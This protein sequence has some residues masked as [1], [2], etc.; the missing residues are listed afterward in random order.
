MPAGGDDVLR[1]ITVRSDDQ[2]TSSIY[3]YDDFYRGIRGSRQVL[4]M[5]R[6]NMQ[7]PG[8]SEGE[9]LTV[10]TAASDGHPRIVTELLAT[11]YDISRGCAAGCY[12][13]CNRLIPLWHHAEHSMVPAAKFITIKIADRRY[14]SSDSTRRTAWIKSEAFLLSGRYGS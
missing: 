5:N 3:S 2:F 12:P 4:L 7:R 11:E 6:D 13:E 8:F 9:P 1:L 14:R 10:S